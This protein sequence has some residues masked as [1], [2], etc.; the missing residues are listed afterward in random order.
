[1][2]F[3][4]DNTNCNFGG[5]NRKGVNNV[6][7]KLN[8]SLGKTLI[9]IGC[10]AHIIHNA[11]KTAADCLPVDFECIIVKIYSFFYI[12][13]VCVEALKEFCNEANTEYKKTSWL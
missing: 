1:M 13:S 5:K 2:A 4:G 7:A 9:G 10:G 12:Y 11:I 3:C 8:T 6:Y